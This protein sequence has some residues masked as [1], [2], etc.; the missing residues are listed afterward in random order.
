M[1]RRIEDKYDSLDKHF[2][3]DVEAIE[4]ISEEVIFLCQTPSISL[5]DLIS[6]YDSKKI[7]FAFAEG[8]VLCHLAVVLREK[9]IPAI[10]IGDIDSIAE[11]WYVLDAETQGIRGKERLKNE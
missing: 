6:K 1:V 8:S 11:G 4:Q 7:A 10:K 5:L 3:D 2:H 9:R